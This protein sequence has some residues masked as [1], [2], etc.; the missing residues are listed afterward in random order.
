MSFNAENFLNQSSAESFS[1]QI[2]VCPEGEFPAMIS[3]VNVEEITFKRGERAGQTGYKMVI[4]WTVT[5]PQVEASLGRQ[6]KVRQDFFLDLTASGSLD[7]SKGKNVSLGRLR[8]ALKQNAP[9]QPWAPT[10]LRSQFAVIQIKH[11]MDGDKIY[12]E[13]KGTRA[14]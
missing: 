12:A 10:M 14:G 8:D 3:D 4:N 9:G 13:V 5:D 1:T 6:P 11:R 2:E 7:S